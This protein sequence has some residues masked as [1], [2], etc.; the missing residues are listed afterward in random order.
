MAGRGQGAQA[1]LQATQVK[2]WGLLRAV[3]C[4]RLRRPGSGRFFNRSLAG[5]RWRLAAGNREPDRRSQ[6]ASQAV[7]IKLGAR[8][9]LS[10]VLVHLPLDRCLYTYRKIYL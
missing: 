6:E 5:D 8:F 1:S 9:D 2:G 7:E 3:A 4:D 10:G